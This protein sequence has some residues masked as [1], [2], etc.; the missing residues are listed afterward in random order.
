MAQQLQNITLAAPGFGGINTQDS[1]LLQGQ[2]FAA[3]AENAVIDKQGRVAARKGYAMESTNG[4]SVLG[5]SEG[6]EHVSEFVQQNGTKVVFTA[7]NNKI[8][9]GTSTLTDVTP[10]SY[11]I[12]AN[13]WSACS[14]ADKHFLFQRNHAPLVYDASTSTLTTIAAHSGASGT[15]PSAHI[16]TAAYGRVWA[17]HTSTD[18]KTL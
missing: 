3:V 4:S 17:A 16:C 18:N 6:I 2:S 15:A 1:P 12:S 10:G 8:F 5:I 9:T 13:N 14:L 11:T 7:G